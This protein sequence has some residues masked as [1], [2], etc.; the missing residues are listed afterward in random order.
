MALQSPVITS[1]ALSN[2][3]LSRPLSYL[4]SVNSKHEKT[5]Y[6][7]FPYREG[8]TPSSGPLDKALSGLQ[9]RPPFQSLKAV[10]PT[11]GYVEEIKVK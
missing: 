10:H 1:Q 11:V 2:L 4:L 7:S 9:Q 3:K 8:V 6:I 5:E